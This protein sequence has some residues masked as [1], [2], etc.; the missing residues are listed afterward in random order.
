MLHVELCFLY[1]FCS[2]AN[3]TGRKAVLQLPVTGS[4]TRASRRE[5]SQSQHK[6]SSREPAGRWGFAGWHNAAVAFPGRFGSTDRDDPYVLKSEIYD[7]VKACPI[8]TI[9]SFAFDFI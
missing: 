7:R 1:V 3:K 2:A 4:H 6:A 5:E 9:R 8:K